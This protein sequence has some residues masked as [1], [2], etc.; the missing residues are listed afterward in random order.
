M[1]QQHLDD[2]DVGASL[3]LMRGET[4]PQGM[5]GDRLAQLGLPRN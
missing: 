3:K 1:A 5:D 4:V 2:T